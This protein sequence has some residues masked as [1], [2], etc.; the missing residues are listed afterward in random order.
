MSRFVLVSDI[1]LSRYYHNVSLLDFLP[2]APT[3]LP[4]SIYKWL[5]GRKPKAVNGRAAEAPYG[6]R[7]IEAALL[8]HFSS[9]EV[10]VAH[11][12]HLKKFIGPDTE[13]IAVYTMDPLGVAPLTMS[14]AALTGCFTSH[15]KLD[16]EWLIKRINAA[17]AGTKA[18]L[19]IGGPGVWDFTMLPDEVDRLGI[20]YVF[21]GEAD[22]IAHQIFLDIA[23]DSIRT[24]QNLFKGF[25]QFDEDFRKSYIEKEKFITRAQYAKQTPSLEEIPLIVNPSFKGLI[26]VMRGCGVGCD[27]CEVTLRPLRFYTTDMIEQ[28]IR[29]N[30]A[31]GI[32]N[33][34]VH[35][36]EIFIYK[37]R[38]RF[39]PNQDAIK[40]MF[41]TIM[42]I[43]GIKTCNPTHGRVSIPAA[44]P[45]FMMELS[46]IMKAGPDNWIGLQVGIETGSQALAMKH[47]PNKTLPL[48]IGV[49][50]T[51][52][53]IVISG[54]RNYNNAYWRPAFTVQVGQR[55]ETADDN[56]DTVELINKLSNSTYG[57]GMPLE[58]TVTPMQNVPLGLLKGRKEITDDLINQS[59]MAVYYVSYYHLFKMVNRSL[60]SATRGNALKK[61]LLYHSFKFG[62]KMVLRVLE[63]MCVKKGLDIS[64]I[65]RHGLNERI[66]QIVPVQ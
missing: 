11:E 38:G 44:Y 22:D 32:T 1:T 43:P 62:S 57:N 36:D 33:A 51:W 53:D 46:E 42:K 34:W 64:R 49:D 54:T 8:Q 47:M 31:A 10:V 29:I 35:S 48:K 58:F 9:D 52:Q 12:D 40:E 50:A 28:E 59:Q 61:E 65:K 41:G 4:R 16:F 6:L 21:Y 45:D 14:Y 20:D 18:K 26:E 63:K 60:K 25:F 5:Q 30:A 19:V 7:K 13:V 23:N 15:V 39:E 27:F 66:K 55:D 56:W 2:S 17:R 24:D 37:T 3:I